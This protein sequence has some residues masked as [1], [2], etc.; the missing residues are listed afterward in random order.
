MKLARVGLDCSFPGIPPQPLSPHCDAELNALIA[1]FYYW[2]VAIG[3]V[4]AARPGRRHDAMIALKLSGSSEGGIFSSETTAR[5]RLRSSS[6]TL[7]SAS[8]S[9]FTAR[10]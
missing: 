1:C 4:P 3:R 10:T 2:V 8:T 5:Q 9:S 7:P 6:V